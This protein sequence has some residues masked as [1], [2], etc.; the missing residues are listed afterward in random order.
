[1]QRFRR[2]LIAAPVLEADSWFSFKV[3]TPRSAAGEPAM[4][5]NPN[6]EHGARFPIAGRVGCLR[7]AFNNIYFTRLLLGVHG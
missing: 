3:G 7:C 4:S 1:M 6:H 2:V 5:L